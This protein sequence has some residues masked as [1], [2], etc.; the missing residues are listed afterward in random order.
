MDPIYTD[1]EVWLDATIDNDDALHVHPACGFL[2]N[3][4]ENIPEKCPL[5]AL[6]QRLTRLEQSVSRIAQ[7]SIMHMTLK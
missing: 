7:D 4:A 5:C 1:K 3:G 6:S 2:V